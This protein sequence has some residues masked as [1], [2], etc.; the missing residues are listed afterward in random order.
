[1]HAKITLAGSV[2]KTLTDQQCLVM[3]ICHFVADKT[4]QS[5]LL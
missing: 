2:E 3:H 5:E 4:N 1:M